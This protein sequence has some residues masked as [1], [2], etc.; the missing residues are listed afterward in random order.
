ME[1]ANLQVV[2]EEKRQML[3][4]DLF[5]PFVY[6]TVNYGIVVDDP[7]EHMVST[8][9]FYA[10]NDK[11]GDDG[12]WTT[13][14]GRKVRPTFVALIER[15]EV[16]TLDDLKMLNWKYVLQRSTEFGSIYVSPQVAEV[17]R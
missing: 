12:W 10:L 6:F 14:R 7:D 8:E 3:E 11:P 1:D 4:R 17:T 9:S 13:V 2:I 16:N 5:R 15:M